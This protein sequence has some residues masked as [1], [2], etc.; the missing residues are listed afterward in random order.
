MTA[1]RDTAAIDFRD[2][3]MAYPGQA[4]G[5]ELILA[6][7]SLSI[8]E[9]EFFVLVGP[10]GSGKST[11]LKLI[12]GTAFPTEGEVKTFDQDIHGP[13][14][15]RGM[16]FQSVEGPLFD[17]LTV[18]ENV[19]FGPKM[20][21]AD[22]ATR[23]ATAQRFIDM[24]GLK[25]HEHKYPSELSG[26]M[27]QR[28]Q[29]ARTLAADPKVVLLDEPFAAL[30]ALTRRVL[31]REIARIW[32]ET[33]RTFLYVTH[34]IREA[35]LLGQRIGVMSRGPRASIRNIYDIDLPYPR[36]DLDS[37][38][39]EIVRKLEGDIEREASGQWDEM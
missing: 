26:G 35:V 20:A 21:G 29:I 15:Q 14:R 28:V 1:A 16:V 32:T 31:Q 22:G 38:F 18:E 10:S 23:R 4:K 30:D 17:W 2:V 33:G 8:P 19:G 24:V 3:G 13:D 5:S 7:L 37:R 36:D 39:A 12:A 9:G 11:L 27:K 6:E 25:G 34:D